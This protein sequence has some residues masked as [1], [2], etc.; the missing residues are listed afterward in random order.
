MYTKV[1]TFIEENQ[2]IQ[3]GDRVIA[4]VSG[5]GDSM[6]MLSMLLRYAAEK[7]FSLEVV[8]VHHGIRGQEADRDQ[9]LVEKFCSR[10]GTACSVYRYNVPKLARESGMGHEEMGRIVRQRA[11]RDAAGKSEE[12]GKRVCISLAHNQN[13]LAETML[14]NIARGSGLRGLGGIRPVNS[15]TIRPV[16]CLKREE[17]DHYLEENRIPYVTDTSNLEDSYTR[18]RIRHHI[19]PLME[20]EINRETVSH[21]AEMSRTLCQAEDYLAK[22][23]AELLSRF[24]VEDES[25]LL[26]EEFFREE[27]ILQSYA[28]LEALGHLCQSRKDISVIHVRH[29]L[30]MNEKHTGKRISLPRGVCVRKEYAGVHIMAEEIFA[31]DLLEEEWKLPVP[32]TLHCQLGDFYVKL[33]SYFGE[34]ISEKKYTKWLD[35]DKIKKNL[36]V[37]TRRSGDC[38]I[39]SR[40]GRR[41]KIT[42]CMIDDK[43]PV[44]ERE[45]VPLLVCESDVLWM[46]GGRISEKYKITPET[47]RVL[48]VRYQGGYQDE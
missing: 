32:G 46:V 38:L 18:N 42:R 34:E 31:G 19:L 45:K 43:I 17:I 48:E 35:Y 10:Y 1:R 5:G 37:R 13:D 36:S 7:D 30:E 9:A 41:K 22:Q 2:M 24:K 21:M 14:H 6:A 20:K 28:V 15:G 23:G 40:D 4:G 29:I 27:P 33:F 47:E 25:Y 3:P 11:F 44:Q 26:T 8:H 12:N 16:L 39:I